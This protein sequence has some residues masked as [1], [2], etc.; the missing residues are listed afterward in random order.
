LLG[1]GIFFLAIGFNVGIYI[2][3]GSGFLTY[4]FAACAKF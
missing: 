3:L 1:I 2:A 4:G